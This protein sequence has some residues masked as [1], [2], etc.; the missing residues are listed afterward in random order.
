MIYKNCPMSNKQYKIILFIEDILD[1]RFSGSKIQDAY[2]FI[3]DYKEEA[4]IK[5]RRYDY[6]G[7]P[8]GERRI[9]RDEDWLQN[10]TP[11]MWGVPNH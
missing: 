1:I 4:D 8:K 5:Y 3:G 7:A 11:D 2:D 9:I 6:N 10:N